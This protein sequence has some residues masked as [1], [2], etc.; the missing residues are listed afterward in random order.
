MLNI[1]TL[2]LLLTLTYLCFKVK[3]K[4]GIALAIC[5]SMLALES[6]LQ[7][8]NS[9]LIS[10]S[11]L[12]NVGV[13]VITAYAAY[14]AIRGSRFGMPT[15]PK[16]AYMYGLLLLF[17]VVSV[18]WSDAP[19]S[20]IKMMKKT[21]PYVVVFALI[22]PLCAT[23]RIQLRQ[24]VD[25]TIYFGAF[26][27]IVAML[28]EQGRRGVLIATVHGQTMESNPLAN[29]SYA[30]VVLICSLFTI[31][32]EKTSMLMLA[33]KVV[34][35]G[36]CVLAIVKTGSRGQL[37]A[38]VISC[39][40]WFPITAKIA[41]KRST[42]LSLIFAF[43]AIIGAIYLIDD[44]QWHG[45][46]NWDQ[47]SRARDGRLEAST[48]MLQKYFDSG[49][50]TWIAGMGNSSSF[51]YLH[52]YPHNVPVEILTEEGVFAFLIFVAMV[53]GS[54]RGGLNC[55]GKSHTL[56]QDLRLHF[57]LLLAI[58]TFQLI[59][60]FKQGSLWGSPQLFSVLLSVAWIGNG[61][62]RQYQNAESPVGYQT[63]GIRPTYAGNL[64]R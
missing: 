10:R 47:I 35:A 21:I 45:R 17:A 20:S 26:I 29:A 19:D 16:A 28:S 55:M 51:R 42:V 37:I 3:S 52:A 43:V 38:V 33:T 40:L 60:S 31:Y 25:T 30:G 57:G 62:G 22:A 27:V 46:W 56:P 23:N 48:I 7:R 15:I 54:I 8:G 14:T 64:L 59:L 5:W 50:F 32:R 4:P 44:S 49:P 1:L 11:W 63:P 39:F 6:V 2:L 24:A 13:A 61:I 36:I 9:F 53:W 58:V 34:I 41:L 18:A 12:V